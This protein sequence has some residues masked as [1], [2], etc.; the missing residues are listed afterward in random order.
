MAHQPGHFYI[1]ET[2]IGCGA[3]RATFKRV[4]PLRRRA[5]MRGG[6]RETLDGVRR[7]VLA[8]P[9]NARGVRECTRLRQ[10]A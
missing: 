3:S 7:A 5:F 8:C 10:D 1:D 6:C 2:C 9:V 4:T